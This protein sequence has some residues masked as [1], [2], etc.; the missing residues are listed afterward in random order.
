MPNSPKKDKESSHSRELQRRSH[1]HVRSPS[2]RSSR[3]NRTRSNHHHTLKESIERAKALAVELSGIETVD[4][5]RKLP[6]LLWDQLVLKDENRHHFHPVGSFFAQCRI[7]DIVID[8]NDDDDNDDDVGDGMIRKQL[9]ERLA[10]RL[11]SSA[12][13][14]NRRVY[15]IKFLEPEILESE[16]HA[17]P[18]TTEMILE[19]QI[20]ASIAHHANMAGIYGVAAHADPLHWKTFAAGGGSSSNSTSLGFFYITD[21]ISETLADRMIT[22]RRQKRKQQ[23]LE[24]FRRLEIALDLASALLHMH[25]HNIV[26]HIRPDKVGFDNNGTIKLFGM[27]Q[28]QKNTINCTPSES[29]PS[30]IRGSDDINVLKYTAPAF[31]RTPENIATTNTLLRIDATDVYG[32][33]IVLWEMVTSRIALEGYTRAR[34]YQ[35]IVR[36]SKQ[37][38]PIYNN[39]DDN[40]DDENGHHDE[41]EDQTM[42]HL[43]PVIREIIESCI[44]S[45]P[46]P[47]MSS[48]HKK[49]EDYLL[50][51]FPRRVIETKERLQSNNDSTSEGTLSPRRN[52][53]NGKNGSKH[54]ETDIRMESSLPLLQPPPSA[55]QKRTRSSKQQS[56]LNDE[57]HSN[58]EESRPRHREQHG[59]SS[60]SNKGCTEK[61]R[62]SLSPTKKSH[63]H[64]SKLHRHSMSDFSWALKD[65]PVAANKNKVSNPLSPREKLSSQRRCHS[66]GRNQADSAGSKGS[67]EDKDFSHRMNGEERKRSS[68]FSEQARSEQAPH[69]ED[70]LQEKGYELLNEPK[71][72]EEN[73]E[74]SPDHHIVRVDKGSANVPSSPRKRTVCRTRSDPKVRTTK[75]DSSNEVQSKTRSRS[76]RISVGEG[77]LNMPIE[78]L[79]IFLREAKARRIMEL[80]DAK[81]VEV[82][83]SKSLTRSHRGRSSKNDEERII[84]DTLNAASGEDTNTV[85]SG[86]LSGSPCFYTESF[87]NANDLTFDNE[88]MA[89]LVSQNKKESMDQRCSRPSEKNESEVDH[90]SDKMETHDHDQTHVKSRT[91]AVTPVKQR[92]TAKH[93]N[94]C[95]PEH[96]LQKTPGSRGGSGSKSNKPGVSL[97]QLLTENGYPWSPTVRTPT[98]TPRKTKTTPGSGSKRKSK[99]PLDQLAAVK[100]MVQGHRH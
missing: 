23:Q 39:D 51:S 86:R 98:S 58:H 19:T 12:N 5:T 54:E 45:T 16:H 13:T 52:T 25:N 33:A 92:G 99:I 3:E 74:V 32:F 100:R 67:S 1:V 81:N 76:L 37:P 55:P 50:L 31:F 27:G 15:A 87:N 91:N 34:H 65:S 44:C 93:S 7:N 63:L 2:R 69:R 90:Y 43:D 79:E 88:L 72:D 36:G 21:W 48:V 97:E 71:A 46:R 66:L 42:H 80:V 56:P 18:A 95:A 35:E 75:S 84:S 77:N 20:L 41:E 57:K 28:A 30:S 26:V 14:N 8:E 89:L 62:R 40:H 73:T 6:R 59:T 68:S 9:Q 22:W 53:K 61:Q 78:E 38:I 29:C 24:L 83:R 85:E 82:R 94:P 70:N 10:Y 64:R 49:L 17:S 96:V 11:R 4:A 47:I 60:S